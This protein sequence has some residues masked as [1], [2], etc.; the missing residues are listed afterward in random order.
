M[1]LFWKDFGCICFIMLRSSNNKTF[2]RL[3][4]ILILT[5]DPFLGWFKYS[6]NRITGAIPT[7][8]IMRITV[9]SGGSGSVNIQS[10]LHDVCP[11]LAINLVINGYD[12]GKSTGVLRKLFPNTLG[13]SDF[14]KNQMLEYKLIHGQNDIYNLLNHRFSTLDIDP[15]N[16]VQER[17]NNTDFENNGVLKDFLLEQ[18]EC[19]FNTEQSKQIV[20][21]DFSFMNIV[22]CSLLYRNSNNMERVCKIIK[23]T[24]GLKNNIHVN[25][26]TNLTLKGITANNVV[27]PDEASIVDFEDSE[28][29]IVDVFFD[30][31]VPSLKP[32]TEELL[33]ASDIIVFSCG[34]QFSSLIPTYKTKGFTE[35]IARSRASKFLVLNCEYDKDIV[36]YSGDE[37]LDKINEY[38]PLKHVNIIVSDGMNPAL[39]PTTNKYTCINIPYLIKNKQHDG[40]LLWKY[41]LRNH[42]HSFFNEQY[43]FD[44]DGTLF[45]KDLLALSRENIALLSKIRNCLII[46]NNCFSN[47]LPIPRG[48]TIYSNFGNIIGDNLWIAPCI[49]DTKYELKEADVETIMQAIKQIGVDKSYFVQNRRNMSVSIKP[50]V[51]R[52][53]LKSRLQKKLTFSYKVMSTGKTTI[54]IVKRGLSKKNLFWRLDLWSKKNTYITDVNDIDYMP[55][56]E[57]LT[58][59]E[60]PNIFTTHLFMKAIIMHENYD[61]CII[62]GG[63][64]QRMGISYPKCLIQVDNETVLMKIIKQIGPHANRIFICGN[65]YFEDQFKEFEHLVACYGNLQHVKMLYFNSLDDLKSYPKGNGDTVYQAMTTIEDPT[66]KI[67]IMWGDVVINDNKIIEEMYICQDDSDILIP[68][69]YETNPYAYLVTKDA[70]KVDRVQYNKTEPVSHGYHDQCIFLCDTKKVTDIL[71][72]LVFDPKFYG[73]TDTECNFLDVIEKLQNVTFYETKH[74]VHSFNTMD[75]MV[76][77]TLNN[78]NV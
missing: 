15:Y 47:L 1:D 67:F 40:N 60:V 51:D 12:D 65:Y 28:D 75:E 54:E 72:D 70:N 10:G 37:L 25:S 35:T 69:V 14:R 56:R 29:K 8:Y 73:K 3:V 20:Y 4:A 2:L 68:A 17:I 46:T 26:K 27:L 57:P 44:Y 71:G 64:N 59:L 33:L 30:G 78:N 76:S 31:E 5:T 7:L 22:Y 53:G 58:Y 63:I 66:S 18:T 24:L 21:E 48:I 52:D 55:Y 45:D 23:E 41:M 9:I 16:Y 38:I 39:L 6:H 43:L 50:V 19:F 74:P 42:F 61:F 62:V 11:S 77:S 34:T 49:I 13:I 36:H 32:K